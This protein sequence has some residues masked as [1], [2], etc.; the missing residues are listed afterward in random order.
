MARTN[1]LTVLALGAYG[2][3][4]LFFMI[5]PAI[6]A[7]W[8][9]KLL[10][11]RYRHAPNMPPDQLTMGAGFAFAAGAFMVFIALFFLAGVA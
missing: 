2:L 1:I 7:R 9:T 5:R 10:Q 3:I 8:F 11:L 4:G 6:A